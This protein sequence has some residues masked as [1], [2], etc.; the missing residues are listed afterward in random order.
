M[1]RCLDSISERGHHLKTASAGMGDPRA[2]WRVD[3][4]R[5]INQVGEVLDISGRHNRDGAEIISYQDDGG[6]N[7]HWRLEYVN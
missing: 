3:G 1:K 7:Q 6:T 5:I 2:Q 4:N